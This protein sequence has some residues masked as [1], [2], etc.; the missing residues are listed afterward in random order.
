M[1][2]TGG[3]TYDVGAITFSGEPA[4]GMYLEINIH[5]KVKS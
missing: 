1:S 4:R 5:Q 3:N 2:D